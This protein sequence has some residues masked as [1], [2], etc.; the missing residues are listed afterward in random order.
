ME[1]WIKMSKKISPYGEIP[2]DRVKT[3]KMQGLWQCP[4]CKGIFKIDADFPAISRRDNET[5]I[6][7]NCGVIEALTD[8]YKPKPKLEKLNL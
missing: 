3:L 8:Y 7:S 6:C 1:K 5:E 4:S 2:E